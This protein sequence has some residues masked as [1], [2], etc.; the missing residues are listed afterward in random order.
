LAL[1]SALAVNS[2]SASSDSPP[3]LAQCRHQSGDEPTLDPERIPQPLRVWK[4]N[5]AET[6]F[7][8][9]R[10]AAHEKYGA[11][12][13]DCEIDLRWW[14]GGMDRAILSGHWMS[15]FIRIVRMKTSEGLDTLS[16][17]VAGTASRLKDEGTLRVA[18]GCRQRAQRVGLWMSRNQCRRNPS[19]EQ[20]QEM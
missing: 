13:L 19:V 17:A 7:G 18:A 8:K 1:H 20:E 5:V 14:C 10:F 9:R 2:P 15:P 12:A 11:V 4:N 6:V 16:S 3:I